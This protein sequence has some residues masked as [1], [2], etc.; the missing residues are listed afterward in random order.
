MEPLK[1]KR[2]KLANDE[3]NET[4]DKN[5]NNS[6]PNGENKAQTTERASFLDKFR[7]NTKGKSS[8]ASNATNKEEATV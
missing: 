1:K 4:Q 3:N 5:D 8:V 6:P 7:R 2:K